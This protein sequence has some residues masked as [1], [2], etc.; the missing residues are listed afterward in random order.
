MV[1][2]YG[3]HDFS[4]P[5]IKQLFMKYDCNYNLRG[6]L[7]FLLPKLKS[8]LLRKSTCYKAVSLRNSLENRTRS[9]TSRSLFKNT[10]KRRIISHN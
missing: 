10:L 5:P 4:P 1:W 6:K 3:A 8:E 7:T 9:I 2:L